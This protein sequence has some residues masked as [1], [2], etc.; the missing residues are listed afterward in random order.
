MRNLKWLKDK[1]G[2]IISYAFKGE[3]R[4]CLRIKKD[5]TYEGW[6]L[7]GASFLTSNNNIKIFTGKESSA[8]KAIIEASRALYK[9]L[10][11]NVEKKSDNN[12]PS[13]K[14]EKISNNVVN[15][16]S[17]ENKENTS[18]KV[19]DTSDKKEIK[20]FIHQNE[21]SFELITNYPVDEIKY[22]RGTRII[23]SRKVKAKT[24][25]SPLPKEKGISYSA[26][27]FIGEEL[28]ASVVFG[29]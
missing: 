1:N 2:D 23:T 12:E 11:V 10:G 4:I 24:Y 26:S 19:E 14:N 20:I 3:T 18:K 22:I 9:Y 27:A 29:G 15:E 17:K 8:S 25:T 5:F 28:V 6:L 13:I 7:Q 21:D 16:L